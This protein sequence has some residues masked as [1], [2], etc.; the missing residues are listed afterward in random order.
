MHGRRTRPG[1]IEGWPV[2]PYKN[3]AL[4]GHPTSKKFISV[5]AI[6]ER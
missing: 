4:D 6:L 3:V 2:T 1:T 5:T